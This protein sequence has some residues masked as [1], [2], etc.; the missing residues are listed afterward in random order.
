MSEQTDTKAILSLVFGILSFVACPCIG[1]VLAIVLGW[2]EKTGVGRAGFILGW[3]SAALS[4]LGILFYVVFI[5][6]LGGVAALD[7]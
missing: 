4:V 5:L 1:S 7:H 2:N 6:I 3:I